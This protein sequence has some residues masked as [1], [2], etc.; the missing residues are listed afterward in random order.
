[1]RV[2]AIQQP[3][4]YTPEEAPA[5]V[6]WLIGELDSCDASL[7]LIVTP[8]YSNAPTAFPPGES[9]KFAR[10]HFGK[11]N[12]AAVAAARRCH[13]IVAMGCWFPCEK[14]RPPV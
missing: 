10:A 7:D 6:E 3:Y 11:L 8:E 4:P 9:R 1:M 14:S 5:A 2:C 13:A 12:D